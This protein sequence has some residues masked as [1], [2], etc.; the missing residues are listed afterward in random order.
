MQNDLTARPLRLMRE[1]CGK[2]A[3][4]MIVFFIHSFIF[5]FIAGGSA[6]EKKYTR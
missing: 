4:L 6:Q 1:G 5:S 3:E 2:L